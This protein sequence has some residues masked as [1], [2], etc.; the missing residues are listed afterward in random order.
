MMEAVSMD[1]V[2][3]DWCRAEYF[4]PAASSKSFRRCPVRSA[5]FLPSSVSLCSKSVGPLES[6]CPCLIRTMY[7]VALGTFSSPGSC[8]LQS[9]FVSQ[10]ELADCVSLERVSTLCLLAVSRRLNAA[11]RV[12]AA[13]AD[14]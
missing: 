9:Q 3:V 10:D 2:M 7:R 14:T 8:A 4:T 13:R 11:P 5:C 6:Y 1:R 12:V